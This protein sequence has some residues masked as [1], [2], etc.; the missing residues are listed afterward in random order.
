MAVSTVLRARASAKVNLYLHVTG[1]RDDG[2]HL[3]D[4]LVVFADMGDVLSVSL[5]DTITLTH[6]GPF[7]HAMPPPEAD[8]TYKAAIRLAD[9][10]G[11]SAGAQMTLKK[12][13]PIASGIGGGSADAAAAINALVKLWLIDPAAPE[14]DALALS[15]GADVPVCRN[16]QPVF[17]QGIGE[18][19]RPAPHLPEL[20]AVL[21]NPGVHV[22]TPAI[23]KA[24]TSTFSAA[25]PF[26][27]APDGIH[28]LTACLMARHN[29]L[30]PPAERLCPAITEVLA[31]ISTSKD[32][33]LSR[34][35]GSGATCFGLYETTEQASE[36]AE[37]LACAH[38]DWWVKATKFNA[39]KKDT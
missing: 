21:V 16:G 18:T 4:S 20:P 28:A 3:L 8:L 35:S 33:L 25:A 2:Y 36:A 30:Q 26:D 24:R 6:T 37:T 19:L 10:F 31:A 7:A 15:L 32:C 23:F 34:M 22:S 1:R 5:S 12:N 9:T 39:L 11:I 13:L 38:P 14:L 29:D 17:M 27:D